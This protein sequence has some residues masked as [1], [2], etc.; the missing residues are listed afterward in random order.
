VGVSNSLDFGLV[1]A[2]LSG[3][4]PLTMNVV[5]NTLTFGG[6]MTTG[7]SIITK[8]GPGRLVLA[9]SGVSQFVGTVNEG[10]LAL[11]HDLNPAIG[12]GDS[13]NGVLVQSNAV[14]K[15]AGSLQNQIPDSVDTRLNAGGI[16]DL[17]GN[18][19]TIGLLRMTNGVLRNGAAGTASSLTIVNGNGVILRDTNNVFDVPDA[20]ASLTIVGNA[21]GVGSLVKT[22]AGAVTV[23]GTNTYTG[24]TTINQGILTIN[25]PLLASTSTVTVTN[26]QLN[27]N[28]AGG[29]TN[30][31]AALVLGG[32]D[33]PAGLYDA[34]TDPTYLQG[35]GKL[36]VVPP[37]PINPLPGTILVSFSGSTLSLSWPT[38][39][40]W[41]LQNQT[42][43]LTLG[44]VTNSSAWYNLAGSELVTSTNIPI[45]PANGTVFFRMVRP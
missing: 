30:T 29:E 39:A 44:L 42:N 19:E 28:F 14:L 18:S 17:N 37:P 45:N 36:L 23:Q 3:G 7:N 34:S 38:N 9:G 12:T 27:L 10:E 41:I 22:G 1:G 2:V 4:A 31:V 25:F 43:A 26:G 35:S 20:L 15:L 8:I 6:A 33:K 5:N 13:G 40:G 11:A 21:T 16:F 24:N 32:V